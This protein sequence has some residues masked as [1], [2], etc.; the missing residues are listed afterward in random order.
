MIFSWYEAR[1]HAC[2]RGLGIPS[3]RAC[4]RASALS[5]AWRAE[6]FVLSFSF[7]NESLGWDGT[8][9]GGAVVERAARCRNLELL[10]VLQWLA[11]TAY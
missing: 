3:R 5:E 9:S 7:V 11:R 2:G 4:G 8:I 10:D 6:L 1:G